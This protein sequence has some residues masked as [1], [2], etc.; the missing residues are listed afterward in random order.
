MSG[1]RVTVFGGSGFLGRAIVRHLA[2][3]GA[4][5]RIAVRHPE[6]AASLVMAKTAGPVRA[7][8]A[9]VGQEAS[10]APAIAGA[11]AVVNA[12][13]HYVERGAAT[14]EAIHGQGAKHVARAAAEAGVGA[15]VHISGIGA[16]PLS[17]PATC[18]PAPRASVWSRQ[19]SRR[20]SSCGRA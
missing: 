5:V 8:Y 9:D 13:G 7:V 1:S 11:K 2:E 17:D 4:A 14:F 18:A 10:V 12:V 20:R 6:R 15:L 3:E 16:D 19:P